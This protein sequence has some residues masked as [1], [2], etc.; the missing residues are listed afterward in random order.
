MVLSPSLL[1]RFNRYLSYIASITTWPWDL[2]VVKISPEW[3]TG[4]EQGKSSGRNATFSLWTGMFRDGFLYR[5]D[6]VVISS[7]LRTGYTT[8][9]WGWLLGRIGYI[10]THHYHLYYYSPT[11]RRNHGRP[12]DTGDRNGSTSGP[13][14]WKIYIYIYRGPVLSP[15]TWGRAVLGWHKTHAFTLLISIVFLACWWCVSVGCVAGVSN[16][17]APSTYSHCC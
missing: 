13:T 3:V 15:V 5:C 1:D 7:F 4:P 14:P 12:L 8:R 6:S 16:K 11:G 10:I 2:P 17:Y 9:R